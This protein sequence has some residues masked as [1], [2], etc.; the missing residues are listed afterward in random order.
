MWRLPKPKPKLLLDC[1]SGSRRQIS[2]RLPGASVGRVVAQELQESR[3]HEHL[4]V[5]C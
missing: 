5:P 2:G 4:W 1:P 3:M